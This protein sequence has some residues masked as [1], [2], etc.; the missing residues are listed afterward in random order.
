MRSSTSDLT[1]GRTGRH[2]SHSFAITTLGCKV[3]QYESDLMAAQLQ[4]QGCMECTPRD[5]VDLCIVNTCTVTKRASVQSRQA[6]RRMSRAH[7]RARLIVT[8]CYAQNAP[9]EIAGL[10]GVAGI[11]GNTHKDMIP[12]MADR[13]PTVPLPLVLRQDIS[14]HTL[15][16]TP[17]LT[18][19]GRRARPLLKIQDGCSAFCTYCI[20]PHTRGPSRSMPGKEVI[21]HLRQ[22]RALGFEEAVLTGI[23]IG[24]WGL[25]FSPSTSLLHLLKEIERVP[26]TPCIRL[27]SLN[28]NEVT[29]DFLR[30]V[31]ASDRLRPHFHLSLQSGDDE[32]LRKMH[33]PYSRQG[34]RDIVYALKDLLPDAAIGVDVLVGFPGESERAFE[35]T[36]ILL[37]EL[38][39]SYLHVFP[40]S[41]RTGTPAN[42]YPHQ[43]APDV[44]N[45]RCGKL[46]SV[47]RK[48]RTAFYTS[49]IGKK[50]EFVVEGPVKNCATLWKGVS[51]NYVPALFEP[52]DSAAGKS[53]SAVV[54][55]VTSEN[56][57]LAQ[58]NA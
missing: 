40:F 23:H 15:F 22:L 44:L 6:I 18:V 25:D 58:C 39:V 2:G 56:R 49:M 38:P 54:Q 3:N 7:P 37:G 1:P 17:P 24:C 13:A 9:E 46:R 50:L 53:I 5:G 20:V 12:L 27:S 57:V 34:F 48:K 52:V 16:S 28:P 47:G 43:V 29:S 33:R 51:A 8:G 10:E 30:Q 4:L 55:E 31:E 26:D 19:C 21:T 35:N 45:R 36:C 11:V 32:I 42:R 41:P 14:R